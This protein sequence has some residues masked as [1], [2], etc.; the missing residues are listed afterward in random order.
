MPAAQF[1]TSFA[2]LRWQPT[3]SPSGWVSNGGMELAYLSETL[4]AG[5]P[6]RPLSGNIN[7]G[8]H[9]TGTTKLRYNR[10]VVVPRTNVVLDTWEIGL[11]EDDG[12]TPLAA[13][14]QQIVPALWLMPSFRAPIF[15]VVPTSIPRQLRPVNRIVLHQDTW[16]R[17]IIPGHPE[18]KGKEQ[19]VEDVASDPSVVYSSNSMITDYLFVKSSVVD[20]QGRPL[21][22]VVRAGI[23]VTAYYSKAPGGRQIWP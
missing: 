17:H 13:E 3:Y 6:P 23:V 1:A 21:R 7:C 5:S 8:G 22:V 11:G 14:R 16:D 20:S 19:D 9:A 4:A 12:A 18:L 10:A 15:D 2:K